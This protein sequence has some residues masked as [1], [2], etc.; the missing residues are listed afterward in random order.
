MCPDLSPDR[1]RAL[2]SGY[3]PARVLLSAVELGIFAELASGPLDAEQLT[4]RLGLH[5][6]GARDFFDT[7]VALGLLEREDGRYR[8][9]AEAAAFLDPAQATYVGGGLSVD[10]YAFWLNLSHALRNGRPQGETSWEQVYETAD[11]VRRWTRF[12]TGAAHHVMPLIAT[13]FPWERIQT[14]VDIGTSAGDLPVTVALAHPHIT[15]GGFDLPQVRPAFEEYVASLGLADRLSFFAG[16]FFRDPLPSADVLT[17]SNVLHDW[18]LE[19]RRLL[20]GK[21]CAALQPGG[22]LLVFEQFID[23]DRRANLEG[24]LMSLGMLMRNPGSNFTAAECCAWMQ[25][26]GF[27]ETTV[28][29]LG[30]SL[31]LAVATK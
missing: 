4:D 18:S 5:L 6:R 21:A 10:H 20:L 17:M 28:L 27:S 7:L 16:D 3:Q 25:E 1:I 8:N 26:A 15:G 30:N 23:D 14:L 12:F 13:R 9:S 22:R 29:D 24:L 11:G 19:D 31:A 2:A